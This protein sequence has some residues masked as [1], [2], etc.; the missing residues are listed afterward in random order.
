MNLEISKE[1]ADYMY[2]IVE[3]IIDKIGPRMPC[4]PQEA[5]GAEIIK[6]ELAKSCDETSLEK[7]TCHPKAFLGWIK[8][9][10]VMVFFSMLLYIFMQFT[11][12]L[13]VLQALA[14]IS[15]SLI[16]FALLIIKEE[17]FNY[18]E[19]IDP[20]FREK[21]SQNVVGRFKSKG[22]LKKIL[23]FS[24]HNDSALEFKLAKQLG[25]GWIPLAFG[26]ILIMLIWV[27]ISFINLI[28]MLIGYSMLR[29][30][31]LVFSIWLLIIG[32]PCFIELFLFVPRGDKGNTVPG[33]CDNLSSC[34]VIIGLSRYLKRNRE[35]IPENTEIRLISFGCEEAGLRGSYRYAAAHLDE[36]SQYDA[37]VFNMDG[38]DI[39]DGFKVILKTSPYI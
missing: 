33:A 3:K 4:S 37:I 15:F 23:I 26:G 18:K 12:N 22:E 10:C 24:S 34:S 39:P 29:D 11:A 27:I 7:F 28:I 5:Q 8:L 2:S 17:F 13:I 20:I 36:L 31:F 30:Y 6:D 1:D 14:I 9:D 19:F 32:A 16:I 35:I 38:L 21:P 25:L